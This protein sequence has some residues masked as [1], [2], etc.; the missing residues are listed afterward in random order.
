MELDEHIIIAYNNTLAKNIQAQM[1]KRGI[2]TPAK[3]AVLT[4]VRKD[5]LYGVLCNRHY[6]QGLRLSSIIK[7]EMFFGLEK[8]ELLK[9]K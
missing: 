8:G 7:L 6:A 2:N 4:G 9:E 5:S 1:N 3:L